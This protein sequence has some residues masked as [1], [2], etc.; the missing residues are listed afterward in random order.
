[1]CQE[2]SFSLIIV[3]F[4]FFLC[5]GSGATFFQG[6]RGFGVVGDGRRFRFYDVEGGFFIVFWE[7]FRRRDFFI[8]FL[9]CCFFFEGSS[10]SGKRGFFWQGFFFYVLCVLIV[11]ILGLV[12]MEIVG[13]GRFLRNQGVLGR[14]L[15]LF[16]FKSLIFLL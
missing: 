11:C 9:E 12:V 6:E 15:N 1:M 5:L 7:I 8:L 13:G 3:Y 14:G 16:L 4:V 2:T 10:G